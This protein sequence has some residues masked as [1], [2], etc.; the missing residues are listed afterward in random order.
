MLNL[1]KK[2]MNTAYTENGA[3]AYATTG[4]NCLDLFAGIGALRHVSE[5]EIIARF[6]AFVNSFKKFIFLP[7]KKGVKIAVFRLFYKKLDN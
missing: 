1:L 2:E 7:Y 5:D 4:S 6:M 3:A